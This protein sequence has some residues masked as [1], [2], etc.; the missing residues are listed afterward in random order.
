MTTNFSNWTS[1]WPVRVVAEDQT[2]SVGEAPAVKVIAQNGGELE[3]AGKISLV[4]I[5]GVAVTLEDGKL[6]AKEAGEAV[7]MVRLDTKLD[8]NGVDVSA[9]TAAEY[10]IYS[11]PITITVK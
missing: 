3:D 5:S 7:V 9:K 1:N 8:V 2:L 4:P 6:V 11:A 10:A